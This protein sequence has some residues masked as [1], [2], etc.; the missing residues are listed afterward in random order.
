MGFWGA[1]VGGVVGGLVGGPV[2][3]GIGAALG[4][5]LDEDGDQGADDQV[6]TE[7]TWADEPD[8]RLFWLQPQAYL[9]D[10]V[11]FG[12]QFLD[13][14]SER[15]V[16]GRGPFCDADGDFFG[17]A[18]IQDDGTGLLFVPS[19]A[20]G[21]SRRGTHVMRVLYLTE[22]GPVGYALFEHDLPVRTKF[23]P[24]I[25]LRPLIGLAMVVARADG[26]LDPGEVRLIRSSLTEAFEIGAED[27]EDLRTIMKSEPSATTAELVQSLYLRLPTV[28]LAAVLEL[29]AD[30]AR[31]DGRIDTAEVEAIRAVGIE[32]GLAPDAWSGAA[33]EL[34]LV[35]DDSRMEVAYGV[36]GLPPGASFSDVKTAYRSKMKDY[37]PDKVA[38]LPPEFQDVAHRKSQ[39]INQAYNLLVEALC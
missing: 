11:G 26:R 12:V 21:N 37:H 25:V 8:G 17:F 39:E 18:P 5:G 29:L 27:Q 24:C 38:H 2:G 30:V 19:G 16:R 1:I 13:R 7:L 31:A 10:I 28:A 9:H 3:A 22:S 4:S 34:G 14:Q 15:F 35:S 6:P 23:R 32:M 36:L 20:L 33:A